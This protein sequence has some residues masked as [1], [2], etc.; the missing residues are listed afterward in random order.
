ML[1]LKNFRWFKHFSDATDTHNRRE[2]KTKRPE[3]PPDSDESETLQEIPS[4]KDVS[5]RAEAVG[6]NENAPDDE[7][8]ENEQFSDAQEEGAAEPKEPSG[9]SGQ[10]IIVLQFVIVKTELLN[11]LTITTFT[12]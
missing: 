8:E 5:E 2:G 4:T 6:G 10:L 3:P 12:F 7:E 1:T 11:V 9:S